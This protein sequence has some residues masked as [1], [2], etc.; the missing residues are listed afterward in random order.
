MI[1]SKLTSK[2]QTTIPRAVRHYLGLNVGDSLGYSIETGHIIL[3]KC[4]N[5]NNAS[6]PPVFREWESTADE[7]AYSGL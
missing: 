6:P 3:S 1:T 5:P 2:A 4:P 7:Q